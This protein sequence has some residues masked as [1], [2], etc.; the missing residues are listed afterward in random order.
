MISLFLCFSNFISSL[1]AC[2]L[3]L[4]FNFSSSSFSFWS[5]TF[6]NCS[7]SICSNFNLRF[8]SSFKVWYFSIVSEILSKN[9]WIYFS[10]L[11][12]NLKL[13]FGLR[14][15]WN[16]TTLEI[17]SSSGFLFAFRGFFIF[18]TFVILIFK[19]FFVLIFFCFPTLE[20]ILFF[21]FTF[22][23]STDLLICF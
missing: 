9:D 5:F 19:F 7:F 2:S 17:K 13:N 22:L 15:S 21:F 6:S 4:I 20:I 1:S 14:D 16:F 12:L 8:W 10:R 3:I 23:K 11:K 18:L